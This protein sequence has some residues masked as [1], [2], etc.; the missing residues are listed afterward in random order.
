MKVLHRLILILMD[1]WQYIQIEVEYFSFGFITLM[2]NKYRLVILED[3]YLTGGV[4]FSPKGDTLIANVGNALWLFDANNKPKKILEQDHAIQEPSWSYD[5]KYINYISRSNGR[6]KLYKLNIQTLTS[7]H[8][9][10]DID[11]YRES[12]NGHYVVFKESFN[13]EYKVKYNGTE[14]V[15]TIN[16][17]DGG[18]AHPNFVLRNNYIYFSSRKDSNNINLMAFDLKTKELKDTGLVTS[19]ELMRISVS[20]DEYYVYMPVGEY[21]DMDIAEIKK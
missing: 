18:V 7:E 9:R 10:D 1:R 15:D 19:L 5:G 6:W 21:G 14:Q 3:D 12:S 20:L 8:V 13:E 16:V 11:F 2:V 4:D 17:L